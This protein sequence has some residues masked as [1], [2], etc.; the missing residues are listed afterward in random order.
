VYCP[1]CGAQNPDDAAFCSGCGKALQKASGG[2][3]VS[4]LTTAPPAGEQPPNIVGYV[5]GASA[6]TL[7]CCPPVGIAALVCAIMING[8]ASAGDVQG[9][10]RL[11][12]IS[13]ILSIVAGGLG[14]IGWLIFLLFM[15]G[16]AT[17]GSM[18]PTAY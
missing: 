16:L 2:Q 1:T 8:K 11:A 9:A 15:G 14:V 3:P 7:L 18:T 6:A 17:L 10:R 5:I 12:K 13:M 4:R